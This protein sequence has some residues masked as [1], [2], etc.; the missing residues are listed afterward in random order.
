MERYQ[1]C[2]L[3]GAL[4][5][6]PLD[7]VGR[8]ERTIEVR[9]GNQGACSCLLGVGQFVGVSNATVMLAKLSDH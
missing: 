9:A 1:L 4:P 6:H 8:Q 7:D 3:P 5:E 2:H